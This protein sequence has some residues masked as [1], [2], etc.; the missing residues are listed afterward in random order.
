MKRNPTKIKTMIGMKIPAVYAS[1]GKDHARFFALL[2][3]ADMLESPTYCI[4]LP[5]EATRRS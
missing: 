5:Y 3:C 2:A 4:A 1:K